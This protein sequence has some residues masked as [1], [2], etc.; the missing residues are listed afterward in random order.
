MV[1]TSPISRRSTACPAYLQDFVMD[2]PASQRLRRRGPPVQQAGAGPSGAAVETV[3]VAW[4]TAAENFL[5]EL[6]TEDT[7]DD[8]MN[9]QTLPLVPLVLDREPL[10]GD[11]QVQ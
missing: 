1:R 8:V 5:A 9:P 11:E 2:L 4:E 10:H 3:S 6:E 7:E